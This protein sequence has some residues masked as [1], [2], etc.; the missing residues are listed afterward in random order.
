MTQQSSTDCQNQKAVPLIA[1]RLKFGMSILVSM[2]SIPGHRYSMKLTCTRA[3][4]AFWHKFPVGM[5]SLEPANANRK[6]SQVM[7]EFKPERACT[8]YTQEC[9]IP[10]HRPSQVANQIDRI[11]YESPSN[12]TE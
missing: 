4:D 8:H 7:P 10:L 6:V 2:P 1:N 11:D 3:N 12:Q 5:C 9:T